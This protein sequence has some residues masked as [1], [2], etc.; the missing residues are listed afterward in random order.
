MWWDIYSVSIRL[1]SLCAG[2]SPS[3]G[4]TAVNATR[5]RPQGALPSRKTDSPGASGW[6]WAE[7]CAADRSARCEFGSRANHPSS[8]PGLEAGECARKAA[9][10][11]WNRFMTVELGWRW[12][13]GPESETK[14]S[15]PTI[16][17]W[18]RW[19]TTGAFWSFGLICPI[20]Y[21]ATEKGITG[22][23]GW[24]GQ[25]TSNGAPRTEQEETFRGP[26]DWRA[27]MSERQKLFVSRDLKAWTTQYWSVDH[28]AAG[29]HQFPQ[30]LYGSKGAKKT[31]CLGRAN[32]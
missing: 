18:L 16:Y 9:Q 31:D 6:K 8:T 23:C 28:R 27:W 3:A 19:K 12:R 14:I 30:F 25:V 7:V 2:H 22:S 11:K 4:D 29:S 26:V 17:P 10:S 15:I 21:E 1:L 5:P 24:A 20:L 13:F 32:A